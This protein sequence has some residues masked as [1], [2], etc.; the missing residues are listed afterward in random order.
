MKRILITAF[1]PFG[2]SK[3]NTSGE[4]LGK[5]PDT[6]AHCETVRLSLPVVFGKAAQKA[7]SVRADYVFMLGEACGRKTVTP[8]RRA[9]NLRHARIPDNEGNQPLD[10]CIRDDG[11]EELLTAV[12]VEAIAAKM[13]QE[14]YDIAVSDDAGAFVCN[15]TYYLTMLESRVPVCFIH[16]P[17]DPE[18]AEGFADTAKRF[19]TLA[20]SMPDGSAANT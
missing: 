3:I 1:E 16:M 13:A 7:L 20:V 8:E 10:Q 9:K 11:P 15:D 19:I 4:V 12:P 5:L 14:G 17:A 18:R 2:G 6:L